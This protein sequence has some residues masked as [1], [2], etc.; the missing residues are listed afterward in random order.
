MFQYS[1]WRYLQVISSQ[2]RISKCPSLLGMVNRFWRAAISNKK[3]YVLW[4]ELVRDFIHLLIHISDCW[5]GQS[6]ISKKIGT[7]HKSSARKLSNQGHLNTGERWLIYSSCFIKIILNQEAP[8]FLI[9]RW[10]M[11]YDSNGVS[12]QPER[13]V[14]CSLTV[15]ITMLGFST[16][17][18]MY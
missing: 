1:F 6:L 18:V 5:G 4:S 11:L 17:Q 12:V 7:T 10:W 13:P 3:L 14:P 16:N 2:K 15:L 8:A 9:G